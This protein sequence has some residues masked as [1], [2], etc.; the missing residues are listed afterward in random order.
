MKTLMHFRTHEGG[1]FHSHPFHP[2][3][4]LIASFVLA[5]LFVLLFVPT[6]R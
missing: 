4:A 1:L 5:L 6:A 3:F 2:A